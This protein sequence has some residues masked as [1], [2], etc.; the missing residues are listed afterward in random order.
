M[1]S[2]GRKYLLYLNQNIL[3]LDCVSEDA[4]S[5]VFFLNFMKLDTF[6]S[7]CGEKTR[8]DSNF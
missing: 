6:A 4:F 2:M 3:S 1:I 7:V 5:S 8:F